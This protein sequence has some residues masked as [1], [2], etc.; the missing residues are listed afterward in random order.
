MGEHL[1]PVLGTVGRQ[2]LE[3]L[4]G[5]AVAFGTGRTWDLAVRDVA[6]QQVE[7]RVLRLTRDRRVPL[8][9]DE[10][11]AAEGVQPFLDDRARQLRDRDQCALPDDLAE[12]GRVLQELLLLL[13]QGVEPRGDHPLDR[14][15]QRQ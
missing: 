14:L 9:A 8:A 2:R 12:D 11:L 5:E 13:R 6:H 4:G 7:E 10:L 1:G 15:G 3:P